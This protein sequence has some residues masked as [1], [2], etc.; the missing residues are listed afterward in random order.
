MHT[1]KHKRNSFN[2]HP[3]Y[4]SPR[5]HSSVP[6]D[7]LWPQFSTGNRESLWV[8]TQVSQL[9]GLLLKRPTSFSTYPEYWSKRWSSCNQQSGSQWAWETWILL[10][11]LQTP[12]G[13]PSQAT[14]GDLPID[15][16]SWSPA[17]HSHH[18][19]TLHFVLGHALAQGQQERQAFPVDQRASTKLAQLHGTE[20]KHYVIQHC[21]RESE[22]EPVSIQPGFAGSREGIQS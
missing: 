8:C 1:E 15:P 7:L 10:T 20:R 21:P 12:S 22:W 16:S 9:C 2:F 14:G 18:P 17:L 6:R 19:H 4:S 3:H 13:S 11:V 5:Q